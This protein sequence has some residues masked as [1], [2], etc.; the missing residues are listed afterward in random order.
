VW[1]WVGSLQKKV[2]WAPPTKNEGGICV[3]SFSF[4]IGMVYWEGE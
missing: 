4:P 2:G 3:L 1:P